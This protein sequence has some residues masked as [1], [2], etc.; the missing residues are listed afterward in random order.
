[1]RYILK[2]RQCS[3]NQKM[4]PVENVEG[5]EEERY[6][7]LAVQFQPLAVNLPKKT[8]IQEWNESLQALKIS[9]FRTTRVDTRDIISK[10]RDVV[11]IIMN[12]RKNM[13]RKKY[14]WGS[15]LGKGGAG[16][17]PSCLPWSSWRRQRTRRCRGRRGRCRSPS[18]RQA[19]SCRTPWST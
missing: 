6:Q 19:G 5:D 4:R 1:M 15:I 17:L 18:T 9:Q 13:I 3:N 10:K 8:L 14:S 2:S 12:T 11:E 16:L 7:E